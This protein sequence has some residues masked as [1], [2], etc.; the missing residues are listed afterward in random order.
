MYQDV[1]E[2]WKIYTHVGRIS[3]QN[4]HSFQTQI[5]YWTPKDQ[6]S[7]E[8]NEKTKIHHE[9]T[10][11][12]INITFN[13]EPSDLEISM[14]LNKYGVVFESFVFGW[15]N[16]NSHQKICNE[17]S[18]KIPWQKRKFFLTNKGMIPIEKKHEIKKE[19]TT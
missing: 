18:Q 5:K 1:Y 11:S 7:V 15:K 2:G 9:K 14:G 16:Y 12:I 10:D 19:T 17:I 8:N 4:K 13:G 3:N 6:W